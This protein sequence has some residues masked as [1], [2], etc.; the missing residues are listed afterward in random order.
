MV[1]V[2]TLLCAVSM[3]FLANTSLIHN[4]VGTPHVQ[5]DC[6]TGTNGAAHLLPDLQR[7]VLAK[8]PVNVPQN[9]LVLCTCSTG[10]VL[11]SDVPS[12]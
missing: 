9:I 3:S 12:S 5:S 7:S 11:F 2:D 8:V 1:C 6:R 4:T 10:C